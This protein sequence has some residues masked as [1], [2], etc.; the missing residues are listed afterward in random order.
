MQNLTQGHPQG[1][2]IFLYGPFKYNFSISTFPLR[3]SQEGRVYEPV[4]LLQRPEIPQLQLWGQP[5]SLDGLPWKSPVTSQT[6]YKSAEWLR[7][8]INTLWIAP[9]GENGHIRNSKKPK[10]WVHSEF[11]N[12]NTVDLAQWKMGWGP[13]TII[14]AI[15]LV[16]THSLKC[17]IQEGHFITSNRASIMCKICSLNRLAIISIISG[18][19]EG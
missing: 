10:P 14:A 3:S 19:S 2:F 1:D 6:F 13:K 16:V 18:Y 8:S 5:C 12:N 17:N 15:V 7:W 9:G 4:P 11:C